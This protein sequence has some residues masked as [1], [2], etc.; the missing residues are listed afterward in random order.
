MLLFS[1]LTVYMLCRHL[2]HI[3]CQNAGSASTVGTIGGGEV[4]AQ[5]Q[6]IALAANAFPNVG[7]LANRGATDEQHYPNND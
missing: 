5:G 3:D 6:K 7:V 1:W 2:R 4:Q